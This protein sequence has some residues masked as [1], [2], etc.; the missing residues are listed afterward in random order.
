MAHKYWVVSP[1]V[2]DQ[3]KI[4]SEWKREILSLNSAM[5]G[6]SPDDYGHSEI[7]PKFAGKTNNSVQNGDVVLVA[8][9]YKRE[10]DLVA[11]GVIS[12]NSQRRKFSFSESVVQ[13]RRLDP[14][15]EISAIPE[16]IPFDEV[17]QFTRSLVQLHPDYEQL[18]DDWYVCNWINEQLE[19][20]DQH[21]K[22]GITETEIPQNGTFSYTIKTGRQVS[23]ARKIEAR[24]VNQYYEW[25]NGQ[26]MN[27]V[28]LRYSNLQCDCWEENRKNLIEAKASDNR[29]NIRM[30]VGQLFDYAYQ[31]KGKC[32]KPHMAILLP[33]KPDFPTLEWLV[34]L[35]IS[36][37][38]QKGNT[39]FDNANGQFV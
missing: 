9:R 25:L 27:L 15:I 2:T 18:N 33:E 34:P 28:S 23:Q 16:D 21:P 10:P 13:L 29:E 35:N 17:L 38:W 39:F 19:M 11:F 4:V 24:L 3:P 22:G 31:G 37:I 30:A 7:G 8:R 5:M 6:W 32:E 36:I 12:G 14:F 26:G 1:N 20:V